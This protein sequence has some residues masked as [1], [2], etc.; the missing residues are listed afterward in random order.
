MCPIPSWGYPLASPHTLVLDT[1]NIVREGHC[2][3]GRERTSKQL[4]GGYWAC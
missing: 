4:E 3:G 1:E 2:E